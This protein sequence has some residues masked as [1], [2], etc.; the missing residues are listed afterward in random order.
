MCVYSHELII[1]MDARAGARWRPAVAPISIRANQ[2]GS[3]MKH[4]A[5]GD[6]ASATMPQGEM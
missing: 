2:D 5:I 4:D 1:S 6:V 3:D